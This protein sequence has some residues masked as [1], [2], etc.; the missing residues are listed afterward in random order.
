MRA[1]VELPDGADNGNNAPRSPL[2]L[3]SVRRGPA[4]P[5]T[6]QGIAEPV[7][8]RALAAASRYAAAGEARD[9]DA[10]LDGTV[11]TVAAPLRATRDGAGNGIALCVLRASAG[12]A[13]ATS[14]LLL[15][16]G[17]LARGG[18]FVFLFDAGFCAARRSASRDDAG[19]L[20]SRTASTTGAGSAVAAF[21]AASSTRAGT[22]AVAGG[23]V[24][25]GATV[26]SSRRAAGVVGAAA[27]CT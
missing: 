6:A 12:R 3:T 5:A 25:A 15:R 8:G 26:G 14:T 2:P 21:V 19:G 17:T 16:A 9:A 23:A 10:T 27:S 18:S 1:G 20:G 13:D 22:E 4:R 24:G 11:A 7:A